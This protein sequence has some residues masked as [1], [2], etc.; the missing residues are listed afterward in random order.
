MPNPGIN[1]P[2]SDDLVRAA[3]SAGP[4]LREHAAWAEKNRRLHDD[5]IAALSEA[6][7]FRLRTPARYGGYEAPAATLVDVATELAR[8]DAAAA[9]TASVYWIPTWMAG[10][11]PT[12]AQDEVFT[13]PDSRICGTLSP[14]GTA[15][16]T[17][18]GIVVNGR[19]GFI[20]GYWH[21]E[22]QEIIAV[23][24]DPDGEAEP[25]P[26]MALVP[27]AQLRVVDDWHTS[28]LRGTG[29]VSTVADELF[30]PA[31]R[32]VPLGAVLEGA[33]PSADAG[34]AMH[35]APLLPVASASSVGTAIGLA[36]GAVEAF[37]QRMPDRKITYT[38]YESQAEAPLTHLQ[39]SEATMKADE[40]AFHAHRL[41]SD[42]DTKVAAG[43]PWKVAE[44][45]RARADMGAAV[46]LAK[47]VADLVGSASGGSSIYEGV[48]I[49]RIVRDIHAINLHA[50]MHPNTNAE[51][52]GRILCGLEPDTLYV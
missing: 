43:D 42:V 34:A 24:V 2:S 31:H 33:D 3:A 13:G 9:W 52:H 45:V 39:V 18:G 32:V 6:G 15:V 4:V 22:W 29:S 47:E 36:R 50:L 14:G 40:A 46:R 10:L 21:A 1:A 17:D 16:P 41:A 28:G 19:W 8:G 48:P 37:L 7:V 12:Q 20:S 5:T 49:Q 51:L 38:G 30:V 27:T 26:V 44:R 35:S 25:M 11:F 23:Q